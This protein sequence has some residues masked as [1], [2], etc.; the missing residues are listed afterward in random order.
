MTT[1]TRK[2]TKKQTTEKTVQM[3]ARYEW[4]SDHRK[5]AYRVRSSDGATEYTTYLFDGKAT[6]CDCPARKPCY[7]MVQL[8]QHEAATQ[9]ERE[10]RRVERARKQQLQREQAEFPY[11]LPVPLWDGMTGVVISTEVQIN[12][13][14]I[15]WVEVLVDN[16]EIRSFSIADLRFAEDDLKKFHA[17]L[18]TDPDS[19]YEQPHINPYEGMDR[20]QEF[21]TWRNYEL[22]MEGLA[23]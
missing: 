16:G 2:A 22:S 18:E 10:A 3:I 7:H 5:V 17:W 12:F 11:G 6:S 1:T 14:G 8:E 23:S 19:A 9:A 15:H 13:E 4:K 20:D 21:A